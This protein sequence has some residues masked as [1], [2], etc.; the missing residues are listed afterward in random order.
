M[1]FAAA[2][3]TSTSVLI[4]PSCWMLIIGM[5]ENN[6]MQLSKNRTTSSG[7]SQQYSWVSHSGFNTFWLIDIQKCLNPWVLCGN[8]IFMFQAAPSFV[9]GIELLLQGTLFEML[10]SMGTTKCWTPSKKLS[11]AS[12]SLHHPQDTK[13]QRCSATS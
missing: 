10:P 3:V 4:R 2:R 11:K 9:F 1:A 8:C 13:S 5:G 7:T 12:K 6:P